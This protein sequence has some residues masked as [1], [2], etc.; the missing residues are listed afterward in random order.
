MGTRFQE[1][2]L[3]ATYRETASGLAGYILNFGKRPF[4]DLSRN[5]KRFVGTG[6]TPALLD[7]AEIERAEGNGFRGMGGQ[8][9]HHSR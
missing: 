3:L 8:G 4:G 2:G 7:L 6:F 9:K 1:N 5:R